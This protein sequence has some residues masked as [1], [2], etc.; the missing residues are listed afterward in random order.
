MRI[1]TCRL[2]AKFASIEPAYYSSLG[3]FRQFFATGL[4]ILTYHKIGPRPG[5]ARLKGLYL[6]QKLFA[7]QL[8]ELRNA[9]W[10]STSL[11]AAL[12]NG[13]V[14]KVPERVV[15]TFDDGFQNTLDHALEPLRQN[16]FRAIQFIVAGRIGGQNVWDQ[17]HGEV[18]APLMDAA[19]IRDWL[20]AGH[21]IGS[22]SMTHPRLTQLSIDAAREEI[23]ASKKLLEDT[24]GIALQ[25]FCYP[26]GDWN[27][28]VRDLVRE[29]G[30]LTACTTEFGVNKPGHSPLFLK[31]VTARYPSRN[32]KNFKTWL[33]D[34]FLKARGS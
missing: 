22:H 1:S 28:V 26:Y 13:S 14:A 9:G 25:H 17:A 3:P 5:G 30:Y 15:I 33:G 10:K 2:L 8:T 16:Q 7:D 24:F 27:P 18:A 29:A 12:V 6:S 19:Q 23:C 32:W 31:R 20:A 4:P 11:D 34:R 21:Q